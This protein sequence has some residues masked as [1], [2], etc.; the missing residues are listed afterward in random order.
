ME[1]GFHCRCQV[2][3][4]VADKRLYKRLCPSVRPSVGWLVGWL[5]GPWWS[6][7]KVWKRAFPPLPTR[8]RLVLA[9]YPALFYTLVQCQVNLRKNAGNVWKDMSSSGSRWTLSLLVWSISVCYP[10]CVNYSLKTMIRTTYF[11]QWN[12]SSTNAR[13]GRTFVPDGAVSGM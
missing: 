1:A 9:M 13:I 8:P 11:W 4:L 6:S 3:F 12:C 10:F 7:W 2:S 5:V